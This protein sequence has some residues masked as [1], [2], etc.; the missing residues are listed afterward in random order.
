MGS[1]KKKM[2]SKFSR[3]MLSLTVLAALV[4]TP[5]LQG[6]RTA[7]AGVT[8]NPNQDITDVGDVLQWL[9]PTLAFG[10]TFVVRGP[11]GRLWDKEGTWQFSKSIS[12]TILTTSALKAI[13]GKWRP[14][15]YNLRDKPSDKSF[16]SGHASATFSSAAFINTRYGPWWGVPAYAGAFFTAFSRV[17]ANAHFLDDVTAGAS[18]AV[19][20]NWLWVTPQSWK[21]KYAILPMVAEDGAGVKV[22]INTDADIQAAGKQKKK[23]LTDPRVRFNFG[24]GPAFTAKNEITAPSDTGTTFDLA[25]FEDAEDIMTT[26]AVELDIF[27][28]KRHEL[29]L[30]WLPYENRDNG[31]FNNPVTFAGVTYPANTIILSAWYQNEIKGVYRYNIVPESNWILKAGLGAFVQYTEIALATGDFS[32]ESEVRDWTVLPVVHGTVGYKF[33]P[34][35][36][37][38]VGAD[39]MSIDSDTYL[40]AVAAINYRISQNWD[41]SLGYEYYQRDIESSKLTNHVK[42]HIPFLAVAHSW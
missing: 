31:F 37:L 33:S 32:L 14:Q 11:D 13:T 18:I 19:L 22:M 1:C 42:L 25:D 3:R 8:E 12:S 16:P 34:R 40:D 39:G 26:A 10:S 35:W 17:Q 30:F 2:I 4:C 5:L 15:A 20:Y 9:M 27:F 41:F 23:K 29:N 6:I 21:G 7:N 36:R 38:T 24:F 28:G